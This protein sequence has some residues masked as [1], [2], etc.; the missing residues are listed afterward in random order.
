MGNS[1]TLDILYYSHYYYFKTL[2]GEF[3]VRRTFEVIIFSIYLLHIPTGT[4]MNH[5]E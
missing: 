2:V 1:M 3:C 4:A 5:N